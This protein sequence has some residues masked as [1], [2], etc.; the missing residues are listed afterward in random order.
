MRKFVNTLKVVLVVLLAV[1]LLAGL[2]LAL[3]MFLRSNP[4]SGNAQRIG[5]IVTIEKTGWIRKTWEVQFITD[6]M[7]E[8]GWISPFKFTIE[9][10]ETAKKA[11]VYMRDQKKI[12]IGYRIECFSSSLRTESKGH[13]LTDIELAGNDDTGAVTKK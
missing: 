2:L 10:D 3:N 8:G 9:D 6:G 4:R 7:D 12:I 11:Q 1:C 13:F 5:R